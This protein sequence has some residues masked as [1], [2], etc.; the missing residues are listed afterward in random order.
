MP[1]KTKSSKKREVKPKKQKQRQKQK[2]K[3]QQNVKINVTQG[4]SGG[5]G[6]PI[7]L[8]SQTP[9]QFRDTSGENV[10]LTGLIKDLENR[11]SGLKQPI[12]ITASAPIREPISNPANDSITTRSVFNAPI[13]NTDDLREEI[14]RDIKPP[15]I[16]KNPPVEIPAVF[17][18]P[19]TYND[20]LVEQISRRLMEKELK[21]MEAR[22]NMPMPSFD[23][24]MQPSG[25]QFVEERKRKKT[26]GRKKGVPNKP[27][28]PPTFPPQPQP[29]TQMPSTF[30]TNISEG[31][32]TPSE[33]EDVRQRRNRAFT[34]PK[35]PAIPETTSA[36]LP[37]GFRFGIQ[38]EPR[39]QI[40]E[41]D[42]EFA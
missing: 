17:D 13:N 6:A 38:N 34:T 4:G 11:I 19:I 21:E 35:I 9:M 39:I 41:S 36:K 2:Q 5:G 15:P 3:Q 18:E 25:V 22:T 30:L 26:G 23:M 33:F 27:K 16:P 20:D 32:V 14:M 28:A 12:S 8:P 7:I 24:P 40:A 1:P 31:D 29:I 10:R 37:A 42:L